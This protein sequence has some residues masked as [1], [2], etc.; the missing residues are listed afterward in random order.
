MAISEKDQKIIVIEA[1]VPLYYEI[2][3]YDKTTGQRKTDWIAKK[4]YW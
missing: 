2:E 3:F 4:V 1:G